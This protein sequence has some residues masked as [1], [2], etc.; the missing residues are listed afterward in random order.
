MTQDQ[1][2]RARDALGMKQWE[3]GLALGV[4]EAEVCLWE[5]GKR[6]MPE[7]YLRLMGAIIHHQERGLRLSWKASNPPRKEDVNG[8]PQS[9]I[10]ATGSYPKTT[11]AASSRS[12]RPA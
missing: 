1:L 10:S 7:R 4:S 9:V 3:L 2:K 11:C 5:K 8:Q 6:T 12:E